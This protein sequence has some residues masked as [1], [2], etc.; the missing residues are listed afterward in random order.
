MPSER[1]AATEGSRRERASRGRP[2]WRT[3][4]LWLLVDIQRCR[5]DFTSATSRHNSLLSPPSSQGALSN[6]P[7]GV[8]RVVSLR[9]HMKP[10]TREG[11]QEKARQTTCWRQSEHWT[12]H[13]A[14]TPCDSL[15]LE[16]TLQHVGPSPRR[17]EARRTP[18]RACVKHLARQSGHV[19]AACDGH[20]G[21]PHQVVLR[22]ILRL[23]VRGRA[24]RKSLSV[25]THAPPPR[26]PRKV[27]VLL[28]SRAAADRFSYDAEPTG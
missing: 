1:A 16:T 12:I 9:L 3:S 2:R 13:W 17:C 14:N 24:P 28:L 7:W 18:G 26:R 11:E 21:L 27:D 10:A 22:R 4:R 15:R 5:L 6:P 20:E 8:P 19:G 25:N 23:G